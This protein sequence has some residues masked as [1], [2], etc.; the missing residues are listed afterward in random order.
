MH[1]R[2][3]CFTRTLGVLAV[4]G[5]AACGGSDSTAPDNSPATVTPNVTTPASAVVGSPVNPV[6]S[7]IVKNSKGTPLPNVRVTFVVT[8]GGGIVSGASQLTDAAGIAEVD[9]WTLGS[10]A[11]VQT[12]TA[13]A[14]GKTASFTINATNSCTITGAITSGATVNGNLTT[15]TCPAGGGSAAQSWTLTQGA[16]QSMLSI[17]MHPTGAAA[18]NT[19]L[20]LHRNTFTGLDDFIGFNDDDQVT[21]A[22][23]TDSR[24]DVIVGPGSYVVSGANAEPG[25]TGAFSITAQPWN[26]TTVGC[27]DVFIT[28]GISATL[29]MPDRCQ[30]ATGQYVR[31]FYI[32]LL[33][34]Q[35]VRFDMSSTAFDPKLDFFTLTGNAPAAQDDNSGGGTSARIT[36]TAPATDFYVILGTSPTPRQT[37]NFTLEVTTLSGGPASPLARTVGT[38]DVAV[39]GRLRKAG[40]TS[41]TP[42]RPIR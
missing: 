2:T 19:V 42:W 20:L 13:N 31:P 22:Q 21:T 3:T 36:Y 29:T 12:L 6:P 5:A 33:Q 26:G 10:T 15:A 27:E 41:A 38:P 8:A 32:Y 7:V 4:A 35:Q 28:P 18:F 23:T 25:V 37:G 9:D 11:G 34:G 24:L 30:Y 17:E 16:G 1:R 40:R 39:T 14:G